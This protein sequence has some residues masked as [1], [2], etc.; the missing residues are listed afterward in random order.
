MKGYTVF[1]VAQIEGLPDEYYGTA[2]SRGEPMQLIAE[3]EKFFAATRAVVR[4]GGSK[5][6]YAPGPDVIQLPEPESFRDA[7]SYTATKAHE[8]THWTSHTTRL[9]REFGMK[10]FGDEAYAMEELVAELGAAFLCV[11]LGITPEARD[12]H[13]AYIGHWLRV[14][15]NDKRAIFTA[16]AHAQRAVDYL[17]QFQESKAAA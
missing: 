13:A 7:E 9:A 1:N 3:A 14:L 11:S 15:K 17:N 6:Y 2:E 8:L 12:D 16:A 5:A 10:R 4:H